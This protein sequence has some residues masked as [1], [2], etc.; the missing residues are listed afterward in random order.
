[1]I[2]RWLAAFA[3]L[4]AVTGPGFAAGPEQLEQLEPDKG[5]WQVEY[6]GLYGDGADERE[7]SFQV[8]AGVSDRLALGVEIESSW[9]DSAMRFENVVPTALLRFSDAAEDPVG[10]GFEIQAGIDRRGHFTGAEARLITEKR[11]SAWW[12]QADLILRHTRDQGM[13][14]NSVA[15]AWALNRAVADH[16]WLGAEGSGLAARLSGSDELAPAREHFLG[17]SLTYELGLGRDREAEIGIAYLR[18]LTSAGPPDTARFF[19]QLS[20]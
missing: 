2:T 1:M 18:H 13:S 17:P 12:G 11:S 9:A 3:L 4:A 15:Y 6:F 19:I 5:E 20:F 7:H 10:I 16:L 8:M 14:A